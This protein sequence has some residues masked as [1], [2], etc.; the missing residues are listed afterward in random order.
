MSITIR[1][2]RIGKTNSPAYK[3]VV[4]N[5]RTKRN[6]EYLDVLGHFNPSHN[7][8]LLQ[9]DKTKMEDWVKKGAMITD[10]VNKLVKGEYTFTPYTRQNE[11]KE[12]K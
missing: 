4:S 5:T 10:S 1:L 8:S 6:G 3:V 7:P 2:A 11:K 12:T 9:I